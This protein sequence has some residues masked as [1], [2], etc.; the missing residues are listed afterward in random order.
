MSEDLVELWLKID[1][2]AATD[3]DRYRAAILAR[4]SSEAA[5]ISRLERLAGDDQEEVREAAL[6]TL[7][8]DRRVR[9]EGTEERCWQAL[10]SD[11]SEVVRSAAA[12]CIG[13]IH[14]DSRSSTAFRRLLG[15]LKGG[16]QPEFAMAGIY[17]ALFMIAGRPAAEIPSMVRG[18]RLFRAEDI[19]WEV[20]ARLED[21]IR[22]R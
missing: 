7:V 2:G 13:V 3:E 12:G 1:A 20:V 21:E 17:D 19:D 22:G 16:R 4:K 11:A 10:T 5:D 6:M 18:P 9:D 14:G 15:E 8:I